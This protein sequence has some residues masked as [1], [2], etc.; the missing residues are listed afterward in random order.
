MAPGGAPNS[1]THQCFLPEAPV[2]SQALSVMLCPCQGSR[3]P[4][5]MQP[6]VRAA[7]R[8][9]GAEL[10]QPHLPGF[11]SQLQITST[12]C[13]VHVRG[14]ETVFTPRLLKLC[15]VLLLRHS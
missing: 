9:S 8:G 5:L 15:T 7:V 12:R 13:S 2:R 6:P 14:N 1:G 4:V 10:P 11:L 3:Q